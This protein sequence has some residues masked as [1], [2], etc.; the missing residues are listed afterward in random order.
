MTKAEKAIKGLEKCKWEYEYYEGYWPK[1][2]YNHPMGNG[3]ERVC[4]ECPYHDKNKNYD[5]CLEE[6]HGDALD[7]LK[8]Q[9]AQ[10]AI[11]E[12]SDVIHFGRCPS[13]N[14]VLQPWGAD[15]CYKCGQAVKWDE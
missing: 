15:F 6:M 7:L 10:P 11:I 4:F 9:E 5:E 13:C 14:V 12:G 2:D 8:E 3:Y 1:D